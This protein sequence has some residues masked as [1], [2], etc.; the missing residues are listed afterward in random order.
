[1]DFVIIFLR[2]MYFVYA[3]LS[4]FFFALQQVLITHYARKLD[5]V[6]TA[7][8][9]NFSLC[10]S[11]LPLLFFVPDGDFLVLNN[12]WF[13]VLFG[14]I[15]GGIAL[16]FFLSALKF[17][18]VGV[19]GSISQGIRILIVV[20]FSLF[21]LGDNLS[22]L[23][24]ILIFLILIFVSFLSLSKYKMPH[25]DKKTWI[26]VLFVFFSGVFS[27]S[28]ILS[29]SY[30]SHNLSSF[31]V[32]YIMEAVVFVVIFFVV[33]FRFF[34]FG[35]KL[36]KISFLDFFKIALVSFPTLFGTLFF[37]KAMEIGIEKVGIVSAIGVSGIIVVSVISYFFYK[38]KLTVFQWFCIF[39]IV[40]FVASFKLFGE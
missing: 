32:A 16:S 31:L 23:S 30:L 1:L 25:L 38:E 19:S 28:W 26:G 4:M 2:F 29:T 36:V 9:R 34:V 8:Y 21:Y 12:Y 5:G 14:G 7:F 33:I 22:F 18:P 35:K 15:G 10:I 13:Y 39:M 37:V 20:L 17:L 24:L 11:M 3:V 27:S 6:S 40:I